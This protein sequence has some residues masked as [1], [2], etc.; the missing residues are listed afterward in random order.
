MPAEET[1]RHVIVLPMVNDIHQTLVSFLSTSERGTWRVDEQVASTP[2]VLHFMRG[3]WRRAWFGLGSTLQPGL[4][5]IDSKGFN[6]PETRPMKLRITIRP[7][8]EEIRLSLLFS[9]FSLAAYGREDHRRHV[10]YWA[11]RVSQELG[12][13]SE[14]L[15]TCYRLLEPPRCEYEK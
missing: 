4:C 10:S 14:Y 3:K 1:F 13:L 12:D 5:D 8:P 15:R 9:V 2:Y 11:D 7:S 6:V